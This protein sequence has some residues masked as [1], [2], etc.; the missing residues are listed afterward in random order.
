MFWNF[1]VLN[2]VLGDQEVEVTTTLQSKRGMPNSGSKGVGPTMKTAQDDSND[3]SHLMFDFQ[4]RFL[5]L[6]IEI[7]SIKP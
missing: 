7:N 1:G 5:L 4:V 6:R 2:S 3:T